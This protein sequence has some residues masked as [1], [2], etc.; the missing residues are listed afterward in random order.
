[1]NTQVAA[2]SSQQTEAK[3]TPG[4][5]LILG[6][7]IV[8]ADTKQICALW[9]LDDSGTPIQSEATDDA[10]ARLI[11]AA[12][13]LLEALQCLLADA[14]DQGMSDGDASIDLAKAALAKALN[15]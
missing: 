14:Y 4:P 1:M 12:P 8:G 6:S 3:H 10:N 7:I 2:N 5:W 9:P 13:E 15:A 11:A